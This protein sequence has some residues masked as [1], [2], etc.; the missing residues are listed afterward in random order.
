MG[1]GYLQR[2]ATEHPLQNRRT[3]DEPVSTPNA[4][5]GTKIG[6]PVTAAEALPRIGK[7][8][9]PATRAAAVRMTGDLTLL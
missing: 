2:L 9:D 1:T 4:I 6:C 7:P 3:P 5:S 8:T